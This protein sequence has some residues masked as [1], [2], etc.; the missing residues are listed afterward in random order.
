MELDSV[1]ELKLALRQSVVVPAA[2]RATVGFY[3][4][5]AQPVGRVPWPR[6]RALALGIARKKAKDFVLA[7][8]IQQR[9]LE[10]GSEVERIRRSARGEID[11]RYI[12]KV[13]KCAIPWYRRQSRPLRIGSSAAHFS[14]TAGTIGCLVA[15]S[16]PDENTLMIL[17]NNHVLADENHAKKGDAILQP[18]STDNGKNP[19]DAV[20]RLEG[21]VRLQ[22]T[23]P[24]RMDC[25]VAA[26]DRDIDYNGNITAAGRVVGVDQSGLSEGK[27]VSKLGR[28]TGLTAGRITAFEMDDLVIGFDLG[29]LQFD[30][31]IEIEG[32]EDE[33][34]AQGGDSGSLVTNE[35]R[36]AVGLVFATSDLGGT[37]GKGLS[38]VNPL[39]PILEK[40]QVKLLY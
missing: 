22:K 13:G 28:T 36:E 10:N 4:I 5:A 27:L 21:F 2:S 18:A 6:Y 25:A 40:L 29:N 31:V 3:S 38:Y 8:R 35:A 34:F 14:I 11:V 9:M 24:N 19:E 33:P 26:L 1:R 23:A 20:G 7:V 32:A 30:N 37:N 39:S 12:G 16:R 17:S 15:S